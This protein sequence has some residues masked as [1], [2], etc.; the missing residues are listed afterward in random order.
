MV[1]ACDLQFDHWSISSLNVLEANNQRE[2]HGTIVMYH[3]T[4]ICHGH[5]VLLLLFFYAHSKL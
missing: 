1:T 4:I 2:K 5:Y 3:I